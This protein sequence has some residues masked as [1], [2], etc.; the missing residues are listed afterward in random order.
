MSTLATHQLVNQSSGKVEYYTPP[1]IIEAARMTMGGAITLDPASSVEAN[2]RVLALSHYTKEVDGLTQKWFGRV[3]MNHPFEKGR[4][5]LW[6]NK[7]VEEYN[8]GNVDEA[9]CITFASTSEKWFRPLMQFPQCFLYKRTNYFLPDGTQ[10]MGV[11]KGSVVTY[12]G[13]EVDRFR[14]YFSP[15]GAVKV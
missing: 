3:W 2:K 14:K 10:M 15:L 4:N 7:L 11:T 9:C 5:H 13:K 8:A 1:E 12:L 6:I